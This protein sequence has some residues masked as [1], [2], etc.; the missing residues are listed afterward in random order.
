MIK[1]SLGFY[2]EVQKRL[3]YKMFS[4]FLVGYYKKP[5]EEN[6]IFL[7]IDLVSST[8]CSE[9][10]GHVKYS[11]FLQ[12]CFYILD[13]T[14]IKTRGFVYQHVGDEAVISWKANK[15]HNFFRAIDFLYIFNDNIKSKKNH[16]IGKY[17]ILPKFTAS[18]NSGK[19][20][21]AEVG[22][23]KSEIAYHGNVLNTAARL[24]KQCKE[25]GAGLLATENFTKQLKNLNRSYSCDFLDEVQF[26]GKKE[27]ERIFRID[28]LA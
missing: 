3:G 20:M 13:N 5:K 24:Q 27:K 2:F 1:F 11:E 22:Y 4:K 16:F 8:E 7:F 28:K 23:V 21:V 9:Q 25:Y 12:D 15:P 17:G 6:R 26:S 10:L 14:V 19:I 18:L